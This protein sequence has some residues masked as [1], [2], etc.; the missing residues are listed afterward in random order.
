MAIKGFRDL[1]KGL[2][3]LKA[4]AGTHIRQELDPVS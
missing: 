1:I 4:S 2:N 3:P